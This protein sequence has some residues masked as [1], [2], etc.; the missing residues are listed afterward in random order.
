[1][2]KGA[3]GLTVLL[4]GC[5]EDIAPV[6]TGGHAVEARYELAP[7][8]AGPGE[9]FIASLSSTRG[10]DFTQVA[11]VRFL[12]GANVCA[13]EL[14]ADELLVTVGVGEGTGAGALD[15][16]LLFEGGETV[17]VEDVLTVTSAGHVPGSE[18]YPCW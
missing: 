6:D 7:A 2:Q 4:I 5:G 3:L 17:L 8:V 15:L 18:Q 10:I 12:D 16:V 1:M 14:R 11:E 9:L 13:S